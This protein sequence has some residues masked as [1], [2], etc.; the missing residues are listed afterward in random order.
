[1]RVFSLIVVLLALINTTD[2]A[3]RLLSEK[4][5]ISLLTCS[6]GNELYSVFGHSAI[7]VNDP[8]SELDSVFNYGTFDFDTP[9]FYL[10]FSS[11]QLNYKLSVNHFS[12]FVQS[13]FTDERSIYEQVLNLNASEKQNL[14]NALVENAKPENKFYRYDFFFDNCATRIRDMII[15]HLDGQIQYQDTTVTDQSFRD[16][17]HEYVN[18]SPWISD[19]LDLLLGIKTDNIASV[20][21]QMF[22]PDY[23]ML[24]F[25]KATINQNG[26]EKGLVKEMRQVLK[27]NNDNVENKGITPDV[28]FWGL[29]FI[30]LL[31]FYF[32][33]KYRKKP[34]I[35][36][37][38]ILLFIT[39]CTGVLFFYLWFLSLHSV[40]GQN[41]NLLWAMPTSLIL[42]FIPVRI[43]SKRFFRGLLI[44]TLS[45]LILNVFVMFL[46]PQYIPSFI[47]P[48]S[49]M[50]IMRLTHLLI[51]T[52]KKA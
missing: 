3:T 43:L 22:L 37:T 36:A 44:V 50:L 4:A 11:G 38:K 13:Y 45:L 21:E 30:G 25:G 33:V 27:F 52:S 18:H 46:I 5:E 26:T 17:I 49:A 39:G 29:F 15:N 16:Y 51:F 9:N 35:F 2:A 20:S 32:E 6:P 41:F 48:F 28:L 7:R 31:L 23:M 47:F 10:K 1:M 8:D 34:F 24:Y 40:T 19:G 14:F 42:A 12:R